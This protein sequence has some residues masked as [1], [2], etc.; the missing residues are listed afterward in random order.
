M[1]RNRILL[2]INRQQPCPCCAA[3]AE[4]SRLKNIVEQIEADAGE[5]VIEFMIPGVNRLAGVND[6]LREVAD[7]TED[8]DDDFDPVERELTAYFFV[9]IEARKAS[10][11][12]NLRLYATQELRRM[13]A[14]LLVAANAVEAAAG[15]ECVT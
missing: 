7:T 14:E 9:T 1:I 6:D 3:R 10:L 2:H 4:Y 12:E 11:T 5:G 8:D 13:S 15:G